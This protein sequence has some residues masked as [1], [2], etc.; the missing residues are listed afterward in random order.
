MLVAEQAGSARLP[1]LQAGLACRLLPQPCSSPACWVCRPLGGWRLPL[2]GV[3]HFK[4]IQYSPGVT[5]GEMFLQNEYEMSGEAAARQLPGPAARTPSL[6]CW[7]R[8]ITA[9]QLLPQ[10]AGQPLPCLPTPAC[11]SCWLA[12]LHLLLA[13][14]VQ[15]SAR[16]TPVPCCLWPCLHCWA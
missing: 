4:D 13:R 12:C 9:P 6:L 7:C 10:P 16:P 11:A 5:Y 2:Q 8:A 1:A 3:K 14:R 15:T